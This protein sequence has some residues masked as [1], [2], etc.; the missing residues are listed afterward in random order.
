V[1]VDPGQ[2]V[3][4]TNLTDGPITGR[5]VLALNQSAEDNTKTRID[6]VWKVDLSGIPLLW[7]GFAKDGITGITEEALGKMA[8]A[9]EL[10]E[11]FCLN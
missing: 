9:V 4:E 3:V 7:K 11:P 6:A 5:R 1:T 2:F 8:Q 10:E